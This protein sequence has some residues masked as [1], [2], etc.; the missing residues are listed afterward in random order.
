MKLNTAYKSST[1]QGLVSG[2]GVGVVMLILVGTYGLAIWYGSKL[3]IEE[4]YTGGNVM[5]VIFAIMTG[6]M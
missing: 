1:Q 6:G 4:G 3:I 2:L 5:N